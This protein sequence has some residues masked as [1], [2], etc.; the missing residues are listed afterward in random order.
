MN[1]LRICVFILLTIPLIVG[2]NVLGVVDES[3]GQRK[4]VEARQ[5]KIGIKELAERGGGCI[6][7]LLEVDR[8]GKV[9]S[10]VPIEVFGLSRDVLNSVGLTFFDW[11]FEQKSS[12]TQ[13]IAGFRYERN[14]VGG[15]LPKLTV[16][17]TDMAAE[18]P[19]PCKFGYPLTAKRVQDLISL[20]QAASERI[21]EDEAAGRNPRAR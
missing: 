21:A 8:S 18:E 12:A 15:R 6:T 7:M 16:W 11:K 10:V 13:E 19:M 2:A 4:L 17:H 1:F 5:P 3:S 20:Q 9:E 14:G